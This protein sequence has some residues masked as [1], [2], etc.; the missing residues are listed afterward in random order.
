MRL[1]IATPIALPYFQELKKAIAP[2]IQGKFTQESNLHLTHLFIGKGNPKDYKFFLPIPNEK[3]VLRGFGFFDERILYLKA[4]SPHID[5]VYKALQKRGLVKKQKPFHPHVTIAR[6][7]KIEKKELLESALQPFSKREIEIP[8]HLYLY[9]S[10]LTPNGPI[11]K[12]IYK[13]N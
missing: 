4:A 10:I 1:F 11:Y 9:Q 2:H 7:K 3:I 6:I 8:F 5:A 12:K 13:Y